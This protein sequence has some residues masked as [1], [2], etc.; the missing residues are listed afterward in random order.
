MLEFIFNSDFGVRIIN[1]TTGAD[2]YLDVDLDFIQTTKQL[3]LVLHDR[4]V[5]LTVNG[6]SF[7]D[8]IFVDWFQDP[9][10][11]VNQYNIVIDKEYTAP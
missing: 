11:G 2:F 7:A 1:H 3:F 6:L 8:V 5:F 9:F 10:A 4:Q